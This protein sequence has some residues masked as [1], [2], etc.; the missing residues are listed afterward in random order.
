MYAGSLLTELHFK[1]HQSLK[2]QVV[3]DYKGKNVSE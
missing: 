2:F 1:Y 3:Q